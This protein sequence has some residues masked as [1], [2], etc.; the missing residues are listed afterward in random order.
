MSTEL[1][2]IAQNFIR[3]NNDVSSVSLRDIRRFILFYKFFID[4]FEK[5]KLIYREEKIKEDKIQYSKLTEYQIKLYSI[6]LSIYLGYY[7]RLLDTN[8]DSGENE[9]IRKQL[10]EKLND[11]FIIKVKIDFLLIPSE[12]ENF[13]AD[14][15]D[16]EKG[17]AKNRALLENLFSLFVAINV[18]IPI[19]IVGKPGCSK[20]LSIQLMNNAMKGKMSNNFFSKL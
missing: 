2:I 4:Y 14:N 10:Y 7:L 3:N 16:L 9:G 5:K 12:E 6:N 15:V 8:E 11:I 17:I 20:S 18:K 19:F 13:I 1:I